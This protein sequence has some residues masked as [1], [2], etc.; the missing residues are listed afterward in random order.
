[1]KRAFSLLELVVVVV[2]VSLLAVASF[3]GIQA[4]KLRSFKVQQMTRLSLESQIVLDQLAARLQSRIPA[5][6]IGYDPVSKEYKPISEILEN[7][8]YKILE[9]IAWDEDAFDG[10]V[11]S[12]FVDMKRSI[13]QYS[14][15]TLYT[16]ISQDLSDRAL[17]FAGTFD[18][19]FTSDQLK[20]A[21]GWHGSRSDLIY[22][23]SV[24]PP[25]T[26]TIT[27][28]TKP[29]WLYEK[30]YLAKSAFAVARGADVDTNAECLK[31]LH[32]DKNTLLLFYDY[33]PWRG[34]TFCADP[35]GSGQSGEATILMRHIAGFGAKE[36][37]FTLRLI[38][39]IHKPILGSVGVHFS[40]TKVVF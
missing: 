3:K 34:E 1:M 21:F 33:K 7:E 2:I 28:A 15:Y 12:G 29:K 22:D 4:L 39:D 10:G 30:Y 27:D 38:L 5:T 32:A 19:G 9:W 31:K 17:V 35:N 8:K 24:T 14:D 11:Y 25:H 36:Q 18:R 6:T 40:K 26:I 13:D 23:I 37:D 20:E 16:D